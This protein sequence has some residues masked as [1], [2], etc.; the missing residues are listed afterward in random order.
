MVVLEGAVARLRPIA[1]AERPPIFDWFTDPALVAPFDRF[2][3]DTYDEFVRS[4]NAAPGD[5]TSLAPRFAVERRPE[6]DLVGVVGYYRPHPVLESIDVW[7]VLGRPEARGRGIGSEAVGLLVGHLFATEAVERIGATCDV[8]NEPSRRLLER[9]GFRR[10]GTMRL[11]LFHHG[12]W[13]DVHVYGVTRA[14][15][16]RRGPPASA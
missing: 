4:V 7:Y 6:G 10:E 13:H 8:E 9:L 16:S 14:E 3:L 12:A 11:T 2:V 15:W 5:P 1:A